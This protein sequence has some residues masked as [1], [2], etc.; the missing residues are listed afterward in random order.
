MNH[1]ISTVVRTKTI[2]YQTDDTVLYE[3]YAVVSQ[4]LVNLS[5]IFGPFV[6]LTEMLGQF[7]NDILTICQWYLDHF[8][9]CQ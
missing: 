1:H 5:V 2:H 3:V 8:S 6:N 9:I 4:E 7:V